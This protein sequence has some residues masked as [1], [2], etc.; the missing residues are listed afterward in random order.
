MVTDFF[1]MLTVNFFRQQLVDISPEMAKEMKNE[2]D[3]VARVYGGAEGVDMTQF[4]QFTFPEAKVDPI[5]M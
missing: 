4:P 2:L 5:N 3:R 1:K